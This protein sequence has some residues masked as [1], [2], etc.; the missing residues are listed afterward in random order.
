MHRDNY[1]CTRNNMSRNVTL[2]VISF[3]ALIWGGLFGGIVYMLFFFGL[4]KR[5]FLGQTDDPS[6]DLPPEWDQ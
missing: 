5:V 3:S 6:L 4:L 1:Y 2:Q